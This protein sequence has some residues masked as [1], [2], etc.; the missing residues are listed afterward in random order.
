MGDEVGGLGMG[1]GM[2]MGL[3]MIRIENGKGNGR[4]G[5]MRGVVVEELEGMKNLG[6][7]N[8]LV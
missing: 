1:M 6:S 5:G 3:E 7:V 8:V 2:G 4:V